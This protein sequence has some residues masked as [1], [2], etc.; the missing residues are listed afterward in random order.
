MIPQ[1]AYGVPSRG[2]RRFFEELK[3]HIQVHVKGIARAASLRHFA[4]E[5]LRDALQCYDHGVE[6]LRFHLDDINGPDRGGIDK[7]GRLVIRLKDSSV[8]VIEE[9]GADTARVID[10][11]VDR[12]R[13]NLAR[14]ANHWA[15]VE[16]LSPR[17][18]APLAN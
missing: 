3:M 5:K 17:G 11:V 15:R 10:R 14:Q 6:T 16:R 18:L 2:H 7:L 4:M 8:L 13:S 12:A 1:G 9:L